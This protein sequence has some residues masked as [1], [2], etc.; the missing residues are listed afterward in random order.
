M[1]LTL[2]GDFSVS[3]TLTLTTI[4]RKSSVTATNADIGGEST[5]RISTNS[6]SFTHT[7]TY[8]FGSK[9]GTIATK[10]SNTTITF[11]V[12]T[13]FYEVI[14]NDPSGT[15]TITCITYSGNT[16]VG[17]SST[18]FEAT[19]NENTCRPTVTA[20][21]LD[22]NPDIVDNITGDNTK[23]VKY[24][25]IA[26]IRPSITVKNS[27]SIKSVVVKTE[28]GNLDMTLSDYLDIENVSSETFEVIITDTRGYKNT[29]YILRPTIIPYVQLTV[30]ATFARL[31]Q[32]GDEITLSYS[33]NFFN[34]NFGLIENSL[35]LWWKWKEKDATD[36][37]DGGELTPKTN[38][39]TFY[40]TL[41]LETTQSFDYQKNYDFI[42][43]VSDKLSNISVQQPVLQGFP[44]F[45]YGVDKNGNNY[46]NI[47]G[48]IYQNNEKLI[49]KDILLAKLASA[50][51][52]TILSSYTKITGFKEVFKIGDKLSFS[53]NEIVIGKGVSKV[54]INAKFTWCANTGGIKYLWIMKNNEGVVWST[55]SVQ[56][57]YWT[58]DV[59]SNYPIEVAE[60]DKISVNY[61][62][63]TSGDKLGDQG[64]TYLS[65]EAIE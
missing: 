2:H 14:P 1:E 11:P 37:E 61:Y 15:V 64:R 17:R 26:R 7:L 31:T 32:T 35:Y 57:Y 43:Y 3:G 5:I 45:D 22:V 51:D 44:Y 10:T 18:T 33:G 56:N 13:S 6:S 59:V 58:S 23:L 52:C 40:D 39:N 8:S 48:N 38:N 34:G 63:D 4:P 19:A 20:T 9:T 50:F 60:G 12:P 54:L 62:T 55:I 36:W 46:F 30:S 21:V 41:T 53:N 28:S 16:E 24:K 65:V 29:E 27:A 49:Q 47:N 42:L 25:S